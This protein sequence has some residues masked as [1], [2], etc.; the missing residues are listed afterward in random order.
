M[1]AIKLKM[2]AFGPFAAETEIDFTRLGDTGLYIITGENGAG[3]T[4]IFDAINYAL[5]D[6]PS[7]ESKRKIKTYRSDFATLDMETYVEFTFSHL[8]KTYV[9]RRNP[10]Y[11]RVKKSGS[12]T[13]KQAADAVLT[14]LETKETVSKSKDVTDKIQ[15]ILGLD[16]KQFAQTAMI[17]Q[18]AFVKILNAE[19][20]ERKKLFQDLFHTQKYANLEDR[21]GEKN[22]ALEGE[23]KKLE[24][25]VELAMQSA[26]LPDEWKE[27]TGDAKVLNSRQWQEALTEIGKQDQEKAVSLRKELEAKNT[28]LMSLQKESGS[29]EEI[30]E[31]IETLDKIREEQKMLLADK[32]RIES[33]KKRYGLAEKAASIEP[34]DNIVARA[35]LNHKNAE[36]DLIKKRD[37]CEKAKMLLKMQEKSCDQYKDYP[38]RAET[39]NEEKN[40]FKA[41]QEPVGKLET[42]RKKRI[43]AENTFKDAFS[44]SVSCE[45]KYEES[46]KAYYAS[47]YASIAAELKENEPCPVCGSVS[48]PIPAK[49]EGQVCTKEQLQAAEKEKNEANSKLSECEKTVAV[50]TKMISESE[51]LIKKAEL[52]VEIKLS[53]LHA[54]V[55]E[56]EDQA[57]KLL[58]EFD[59]AN[60]AKEKAEKDLLKAE[61]ELQNSEKR[62][63]ETVAE[64]NEAQEEFKI[65]LKEHAFASDEEYR[66]CLLPKN[67][68]Q[69][70]K[71]EL[72]AYDHKSEQ[73][74]AQIRLLEEKTKGKKSQDLSKLQQEIE[75]VKEEIKTLEKDTTELETRM[76]K[77]KEISDILSSREQ[78]IQKILRK[79]KI[80][81]D[82]YKTA[83]G[84]KSQTL[85]LSLETYVQRY[86]FRR[87]IA[88]ANIRLNTL[89]EGM[90]SLK[91]KEGTNDNRKEAGL[92][93]E[94]WD[95]LTDKWRDVSTL[96]TGESFK[97]TL[98]LALGLADVVSQG[99]GAI[100]LDSMFID[101]GFGSLDEESLN[102][103]KS[104]LL[105]LADGNRSI[106]V[107]SHVAGLKEWI[108]HKI[109]LT[110]RSNG[111]TLVV[112]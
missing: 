17:A 68:L 62:L 91:C 104:M 32:D 101:E 90:F 72:D 81:D 38:A 70:L 85:H 22:K 31:S 74:E 33:Q 18:G 87:I 50:Y 27:K 13:T 71:V 23:K 10:E 84:S 35:I 99:S 103:A 66:K 67:E 8:G 37:L 63:Q 60:K 12:G 42:N 73:L 76:V 28:V 106:G 29:A 107:I 20:E 26:I 49:Y 109:V 69:A 96:S 105:Q 14:C 40:R 46:K 5:Y 75:K 77:N 89:T 98:C 59:Q 79:W 6:V 102:H 4:T 92:D 97:A 82:L 53:D 93:L 16:K 54:K 56:L 65:A 44:E 111:S 52:P 1:R 11:E 51:E 39:L 55:T 15:E 95:R 3:K 41:L 36:T 19:S 88:A 45:K 47:Q 7:D 30:N 61:T 24:S 100:R 108:D 58:D 48:H 9:V 112:I 78:T 57:K 80:V 64:E 34:K 2:S 86:Y 43:K 21:L 25:E 110:K 83:S 94:V